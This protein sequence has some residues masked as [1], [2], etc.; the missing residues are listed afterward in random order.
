VTAR[1]IVLL[2]PQA[3]RPTLGA[4]VS[5][6]GIEG[7][8]AAITA[9]W[10]EWESDLDGLR[11]QLRGHEVIPLRL[12]ERAERIWASDPELR[13]AHQEMQSNLR[14]LRQL[15]AKR[16]DHAAESWMELLDATGPPEVLDAERRDALASIQALDAHHLELF[17]ELREE[18]RR[19]T[20]LDSRPAI[21][22]V[23]AVILEE[24][25]RAS[26]VVIEG[27]HA[28]VLH[29]RIHLFGLREALAGVT[30]VGCA[31]GAM[32][33]C[34]RVVLY[35]DNPAIGRGN[36]EVGLPGLGLAPDIVAL[37]DATARLRVD[38]PRRMRRLA[39]RLSP[40]RCALLDP[41]D[42]LDWDGARFVSAGSRS[43]TP[44]GR[45]ASWESAA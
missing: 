31:A 7:P 38:D 5:D 25:G 27:G 37:P 39:L 8:V 18:V 21:V 30:L 33:L 35:N 34:R 10:Q 36:A 43:V 20:H 11:S 44:E 4:V 16:L 15:Y 22:D 40:D 24:I 26:A 6:L 12:Y 3:D 17:E 28:A 45:I 32:I 14:T 13:S 41:G 2:G 29:N 9:G 1:R 23:R 19:R 42:R